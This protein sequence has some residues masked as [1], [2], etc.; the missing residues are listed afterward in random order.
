MPEQPSS[1]S[2]CSGLRPCC[3]ASAALL[4]LRPIS[5]RSRPRYWRT[6]DIHSKPAT[7]RNTAI[8]RFIVFSRLRTI[9]RDQEWMGKVKQVDD[10]SDSIEASSDNPV[11]HSRDLTCCFLRLANLDSGVFE[12]LGRYETALWRQIV[13]TLLALRATRYR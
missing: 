3:G 9:L 12:R 8:A 2:S 7:K 5:C 6:A 1:A 4:P 10:Q 11:A 13:Q